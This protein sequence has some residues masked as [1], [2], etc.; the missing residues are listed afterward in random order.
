MSLIYKIQGTSLALSAT[1]PENSRNDSTDF[2]PTRDSVNGVLTTKL[3]ITHD[4]AE[5][6]ALGKT[7]YHLYTTMITLDKPHRAK[8]LAEYAKLSTGQVYRALKKLRDYG[9]VE[10]IEGGFKA[11]P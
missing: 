11:I 10:K 6:K 4:A 9:L 3:P 5:R 8:A 1:F 7:A 2:S